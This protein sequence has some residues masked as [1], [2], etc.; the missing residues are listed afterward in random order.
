MEEVEEANEQKNI[1]EGNVEPNGGNLK[2]VGENEEDDDITS[3]SHEATMNFGQQEFEEMAKI[4][5]HENSQTSS[6]CVTLLILN[7]C[8]T[9][10]TS[11]VFITELLGLLK[12][13]HITHS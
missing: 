13:K 5:L 6:L 3:L 4:P 12:K 8:R 9:H 1:E 11:N 2:Y 7:C 10:G